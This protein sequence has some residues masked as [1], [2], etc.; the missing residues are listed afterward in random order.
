M[1]CRSW[2]YGRSNAASVPTSHSLRN[3]DPNRRTSSERKMPEN[4][5]KSRSFAHAGYFGNF[6]PDSTRIAPEIGVRRKIWEWRSDSDWHR[7][8]QVG[9]RA[10]RCEPPS[11]KSNRS[12]RIPFSKPFQTRPSRIS[13]S[14]LW[15]SGS[16]GGE[17]DNLFAFD[18]RGGL[19][20]SVA[21][22]RGIGSTSVGPI[23]ISRHV[24]PC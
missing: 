15:S 11:L 9:Q 8:N 4:P 2:S 20:C 1:N 22:D 18:T 23:Q 13:K 10:A 7:D 12:R 14:A 21:V 17:P 3:N 16:L 6:A 5:G 24:T 19:E